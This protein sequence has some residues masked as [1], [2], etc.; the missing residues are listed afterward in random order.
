MTYVIVVLHN[1]V[2][3]AFLTIFRLQPGFFFETGISLATVINLLQTLN[4]IAGI[5]YSRSPSYSTVYYDACHQ[6]I[7]FR[8]R[9]FHNYIHSVP[10]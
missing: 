10:L 2:W 1:C 8:G 7:D 3:R 9:V 6:Y 5:H 4:M